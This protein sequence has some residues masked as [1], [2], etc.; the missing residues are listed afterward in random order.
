MP[1][2]LSILITIA[3]VFL[4]IEIANCVA[5][6][7][8]ARDRHT[9]LVLLELLDAK[10]SPFDY[11]MISCRAGFI[12]IVPLSALSD[13]YYSPDKGTPVRILRFTT[14]HRE[15]QQKFQQLQNA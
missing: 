1:I 2:L 6:G 4:A 13:Y 10:L 12:S 5:Y 14:L 3:F 7:W 8:F 9:H 11:E 15:I